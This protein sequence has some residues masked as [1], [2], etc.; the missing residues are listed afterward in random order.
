MNPFALIDKFYPEDNELKHILLVHSRS[1]A[2]KALA[3]AQKHPELNLD[4][5]FIGEAAVL[6]DIGI[7]QTDA[8]DIQCFGTYP[9]ICH[10][11]LG[12]DLV[13]KEGFPRHALVCERH[14]GAGLSLQNILDRGLPLP[15]RDML[16]VSMEEQI[17]CFADKFFSKT[18]LDKEKSL[19]KARKS[20]AK[21]GEEGAVRFDHWCELFL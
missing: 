17:I 12:A 21:H 13:R 4:L 5:A 10:G 18:K 7:F 14:T 11:Y 8:P 9:Y 2:D 3:L 6:H 1:V 19:D 15:H 16:P 20:V